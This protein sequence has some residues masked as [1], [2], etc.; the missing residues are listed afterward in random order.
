VSSNAK[1][2]SFKRI[3]DGM[4][5][6]GVALQQIDQFRLFAEELE[7]PWAAV[8]HHTSKSIALPVIRIAMPGMMVYLRD[9]FHDIN[10]CV[11]ADAPLTT[12]VSVLFEG[13][14]EPLSWDWYLEQVERCQ[15]YSWKDWTNE[16]MSAPDL[17]CLSND[18]PWYKVKKPETKARWAK[19][20]TDPAWFRHDWSSSTIVWEGDFGPGVTMWVL[21]HAYLEGI[22]GLVPPSA[23]QPYE[24]GCSRFALALSNLDQATLCIQRLGGRP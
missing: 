10:L 24:P 19:R 15:N 14:L 11:V 17:L 1:L 20:M 6:K 8:G 22:S 2:H 9:N 18:D 16:Q 13:V 4:L 21:D 3:H 12:P 23:A 7:F 5:W